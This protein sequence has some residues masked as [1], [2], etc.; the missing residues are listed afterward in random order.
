LPRARAARQRDDL[1]QYRRFIWAMFSEYHKPMDM[2][3]LNFDAN[4]VRR[5]A[6]QQHCRRAFPKQYY[7]DGTATH[8]IY[9]F[10]GRDRNSIS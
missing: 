1:R 4:I 8:E 2:S 9:Q 7:N 6:N 5:G 10:H 3:M